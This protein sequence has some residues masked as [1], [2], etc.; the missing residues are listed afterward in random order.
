MKPNLILKGISTRLSTFA[1][2][3]NTLMEKCRIDN[4]VAN[5]C[6]AG[7]SYYYIVN[8]NNFNLEYISEDVR[9]IL[10][11]N[12]NSL[13]FKGLADRIH[14]DDIY[15]AVLAE[16]IAINTFNH[17]LSPDNAF[18]FKMSFCLR[19]GVKD[20]N[21]KLFLHQAIILETDNSGR[22]QR[23]LNIHTDISHLTS[24]NNDKM[25]LT[26]IN[27][28]S[29]FYEIDIRPHIVKEHKSTVYSKR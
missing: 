23:A 10:G 7:P 21:Y 2:Q 8:F 16:D 18:N 11:V 1:T 24:I 15:Y 6:T 12:P 4:I 19:L 27:N 26:N 14:P 5:V 25:Y 22:F 9:S 3:K 28:T 20:D 13:T 29:E 17:C